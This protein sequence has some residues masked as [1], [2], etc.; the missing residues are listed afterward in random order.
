MALVAAKAGSVRDIAS[1][2]ATA[3]PTVEGALDPCRPVHGRKP[4]GIAIT[5]IMGLSLSQD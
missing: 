1:L 5:L 3:V 4:L 2:E